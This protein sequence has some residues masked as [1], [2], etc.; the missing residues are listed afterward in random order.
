MPPLIP[1]TTSKL[2]ATTSKAEPSKSVANPSASTTPTRKPR[3]PKPVSSNVQTT[4]IEANTAASPKTT[5]KS[6]STVVKIVPVSSSVANI[7]T[8]VVTY[9]TPSSSVATSAPLIISEPEQSSITQE[10]PTTMAEVSSLTSATPERMPTSSE[11][12]SFT[13]EISPITSGDSTS[14]AP[15]QSS[16]TT[17]FSKIV[18]EIETMS[19]ILSII[20]ERLPSSII[21]TTPTQATNPTTA[22]AQIAATNPVNEEPEI[23][24]PINLRFKVNGRNFHV[25]NKYES[26]LTAAG[27]ICQQIR[28][29]VAPVTSDSYQGV[30]DKLKDMA[31]GKVIIGSWNGDSYSLTGDN[32]L[33]LQVNHGIS[34]GTCGDAS[35]I[36]CQSY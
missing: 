5:I 33:I 36:L 21:T 7:D 35:A 2:P 27:L 16:P 13:S 12:S 1:A 8:L 4:T 24:Q 17:E 10:Q 25:I 32:C 3:P 28:A 31:P 34:P 20:D 19:D 22:N 18:P 15:E 9:V 26:S 11:Q 30:A 29:S 6:T 23:V 14:T